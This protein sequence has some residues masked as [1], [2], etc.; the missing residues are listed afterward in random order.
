MI[1]SWIGGGQCT[2]INGWRRRTEVANVGRQVPPIGREPLASIG[3]L[4]VVQKVS[5][6]GAHGEAAGAFRARKQGSRLASAPA[7]MFL[8]MTAWTPQ[9]PST[10]CVI[11]KSTAI[12]ISEIASSSDKPFVVIRKCRILRNASRMARSTE[13][14]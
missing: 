8:R 14:F 9:L 3:R 6:L 2:S 11:P 1:E 5:G 4:R 10:T 13:D 7:K 12:D